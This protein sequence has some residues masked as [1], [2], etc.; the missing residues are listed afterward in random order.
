MGTGIYCFSKF[1]FSIFSLQS[2]SV[3]WKVAVKSLGKKKKLFKDGKNVGNIIK[4]N[5]L[6]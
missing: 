1:Q 4:I 2:E 3:I 6:K 5:K